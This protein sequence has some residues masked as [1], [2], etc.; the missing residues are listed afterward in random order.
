[1]KLSREIWFFLGQDYV[2]CIEA[3]VNA[4]TIVDST[5][6]LGVQ[7]YEQLVISTFE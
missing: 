6:L 1:M 7:A 2:P 4:G 5:A 3:V